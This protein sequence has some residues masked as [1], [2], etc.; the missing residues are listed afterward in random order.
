MYEAW[1]LVDLYCLM[2]GCFFGGMVLCRI[3]MSPYKPPSDSD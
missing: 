1:H 2:I 3:I